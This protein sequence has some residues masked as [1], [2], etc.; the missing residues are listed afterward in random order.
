MPLL[1]PLRPLTC[2]ELRNNF[3]A[4]INRAEHRGLQGADTIFDLYDTVRAY[5]YIRTL[6]EQVNALDTELQQLR[7]DLF[8]EG[9]LQRIIDQV[10]QMIDDLENNLEAIISN[11]QVIEDLQ[12]C[13]QT[14]TSAIAGLSTLITS[15]NSQLTASITQLQASV[16]TINATI[17][18][19]LRPRLVA[20]ETEVLD[21]RSDHEAAVARITVAEGTI[22]NINSTIS[23]ELRPRI[24][25]LET[26]LS[27]LELIVNGF[28]GRITTVEGNINTINNTINTDLRPRIVTLEGFR[29]EL[30]AIVA[31]IQS[32]VNTLN[33][34]V[35]ND[36]RPRL[37]ALEDIQEEVLADIATL[38]AGVAAINTTLTNDI[39]PRVVALE[40]RTGLLET[41]RALV[42]SPT[43]IGI[44]KTPWPSPNED[45]QIAPVGWVNSSIFNNV[46]TTR[47]PVGG[48]IMWLNASIP[49]GWLLCNGASLSRSVYPALFGVLGYASGGSGDNFNLPDMQGRFPFGSNGVYPIYA[50]GG[51]ESVTLSAAQMPSHSHNL[52]DPGHS[53]TYFDP[54]HNHSIP[55]HRHNYTLATPGGGPQTRQA[56]DGFGSD[57]GSITAETGVQL[58]SGQNTGNKNVNISINGASSGLSIQNTGNNEGHNNM[59]PYHVL[60]FIIRAY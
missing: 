10:T 9:E 49:Q 11:L 29:A 19:E 27:A 1:L 58:P 14:N 28:N 20:L 12:T 45:A 52:I 2:D 4:A 60:L 46:S 50:K 23:T 17:N 21:L 54:G 33:N 43:F 55:D 38:E 37:L 22:N 3:L 8:G 35:N 32:T 25:T 31:T 16:N 26:E 24:V 41:T 40:T 13:C 57:R 36:I 47:V 51:A 59:P 5:D 18:T 48:I 30:N 34:V 15:I 7:D 53:H 42:N 56:A 6:Q 39:T 44:P